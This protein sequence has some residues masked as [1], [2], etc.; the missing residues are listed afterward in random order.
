MTAKDQTPVLAA[1]GAGGGTTA[2]MGPLIESVLLLLQPRASR[3]RDR[4]EIQL[5]VLSQG[6]RIM[7]ILL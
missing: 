3:P 6:R 2:G 5:R 4:I 1:T 7:E